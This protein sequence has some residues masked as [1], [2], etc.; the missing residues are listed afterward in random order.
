MTIPKYLIPGYNIRKQ[1]L[2]NNKGNK[3]Q[4]EA[5]TQ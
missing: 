3:N 1:I 4:M 2:I 5:N